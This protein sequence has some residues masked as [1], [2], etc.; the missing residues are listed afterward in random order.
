MG[1]TRH[2]QSEP[3]VFPF[4]TIC[5]RHGERIRRYHG[6]PQCVME[7]VRRHEKRI[8]TSIER[9]LPLAADS[10]AEASAPPEIG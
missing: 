6:C 3:E 10:I 8:H 7:E 5:P 9:E 4:E 1:T 2:E